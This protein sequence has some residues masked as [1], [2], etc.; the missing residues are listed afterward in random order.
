MLESGHNFISKLQNTK[1][2]LLIK[3]DVGKSKPNT[4]DLP[5]NTFSYGIK[6]NKDSEDAGAVISSWAK[7][8]KKPKMPLEQNF[9]KLNMLSITE[10][11]VTATQQRMFRKTDFHIR[12]NSE[13]PKVIEDNIQYIYGMP[14]RPSTPIKAV[15]GNFYGY[16][17]SEEKHFAYTAKEKSGNKRRALVEKTI[18]KQIADVDDKKNLFKMKKFLKVKARTSTRRGQSC[19]ENL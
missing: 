9:K 2:C 18:K 13:E 12:Q 7:T 5:P 6:V 10:K 1:N 4:R 8:A 15:L 14:L 11:Q 19:S 17:A 16:V 3:D